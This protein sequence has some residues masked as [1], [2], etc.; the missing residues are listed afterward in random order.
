MRNDTTIFL[1]T[2]VFK[3]LFKV[4]FIDTNMGNIDEGTTTII[5][6]KGDIGGFNVKMVIE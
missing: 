2:P 3:K 1:Y 4:L 5:Y 6:K